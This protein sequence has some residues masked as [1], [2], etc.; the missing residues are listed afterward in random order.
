MKTI[1]VLPFANV[2][3]EGE[4]EYLADGLT[5]DLIAALSRVRALRVVARTS[6]F[7]FKDGTRDVR[8]IGRALDVATV[9]EGS[10]ERVG[11]RVR[12]AVRLTNAA[13]GSRLS[14]WT[15]DRDLADVFAI[16]ADLVTRIAAAL[17]TEPTTAERQRLARASTTSPEAFA[18]YL[19]GRHFWHQRTQPSYERAVEYFAR[20]ID[21]DPAFAAAHAGLAAVY[22]QQGMIGALSP[23]EAHRRT[24]E[25]AR[26]AVEL[27]DGF[28]EAHS[29]LAVHLHA[30]DWNAA[31]AER[32]H[33]LAV[34]LEPGNPTPHYLY[35]NFLRAMGRVDEAIAQQSRAVELDP[36][37]P[38]LT[39]TL[40]FTLLR[41]GRVAE[42]YAR[43]SDAIEM[44]STY[45]RAHAVLGL[46]HERAGRPDDALRELER[47]NML[48]G[49]SHHRTTP[50]IARV[51][52]G[53]GRIQEAR[54]LIAMLRSSSTDLYVAT[55]LLA[56]GDVEGAHAWL[57]RA[58]RER[59]PHLPF[60]D[61]DPRFAP[62]EADPLFIDLMR[63][64]GVRRAGV[65]SSR[66]PRPE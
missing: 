51:L 13:D 12:V 35:G 66:D 24:L 2:S 41:A 34:T 54:Q 16:R 62:F 21:I 18:L 17:E 42:A 39:E 44:D 50:D 36:L 63:R 37:A 11:D 33:V 9:L 52:A 8:E 49:P 45:W 61:G 55:A 46:I 3:R 64:V 47:A 60:L 10:V 40:A 20:A 59:N 31:A 14:S 29:M 56:V 43:V 5:E 1:A 6:A 65:V 26:R 28:A 22:S 4:E 30:H 15:Y 25:S 19:K 38:A 27:D 58:Y 32:E 7:T 57:D 23:R 53:T 48:A